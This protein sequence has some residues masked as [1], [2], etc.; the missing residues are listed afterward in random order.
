[1]YKL[2]KSMASKDVFFTGNQ[3]LQNKDFDVK[4]GDFTVFSK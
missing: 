4:K 2:H 1:M 3:Y